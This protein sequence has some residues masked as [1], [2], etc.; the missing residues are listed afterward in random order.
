VILIFLLLVAAAVFAISNHV[1]IPFRF[2]MRG[3]VIFI[4]A[5]S[6]LPWLGAWTYLKLAPDIRTPHRDIEYIEFSGGCLTAILDLIKHKLIAVHCRSKTGERYPDVLAGAP[7]PGLAEA[8]YRLG[9]LYLLG[10]GVK[11]DEAKGQ[12]LIKAATIDGFVET[13]R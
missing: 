12:N 9:L 11:Q 3:V 5:T 4:A 1:T 7:I 13:E 10:R 6:T 2:A 8:Q